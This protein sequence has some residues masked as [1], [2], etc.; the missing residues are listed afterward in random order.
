MIPLYLRKRKYL[1]KDLLVELKLVDS[2]SQ[3]QRLIEQGA[4]EIDGKLIDNPF[5][6]IEPKTGEI[7]KVGKYKF[8]KIEL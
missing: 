4:V 3:A 2:K 8:K 7:V 1:A 5:L 6:E